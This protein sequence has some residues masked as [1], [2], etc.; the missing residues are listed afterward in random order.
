METQN[1]YIFIIMGKPFILL[2]PNIYSDS[3]IIKKK[4][5]NAILAYFTSKYRPPN[6]IG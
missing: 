5:L 2:N 1:I 6:W 4:K 3:G